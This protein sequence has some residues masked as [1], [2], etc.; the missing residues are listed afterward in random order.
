M[1]DWIPGALPRAAIGRRLLAPDSGLL[2]QGVRFA[3][4][5]SL[6]ALVYLLTTTLLAAVVGLPFQVALPLGLG[7]AIVVHFTLQRM[8]VWTPSG[9]FALPL[10]HQA[11]RYLS[12]V[13]VQYG[14]TAASTALLPHALGIPTEIVFLVTAVLLGATN[15]VVFRH[16]VFHPGAVI[17]GS[18]GRSR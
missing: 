6:T 5:G 13:G 18:E 4:V 15:F 2:G 9:E 17:A 11:G 7:L 10:R 3:L 1:R 14:L 12:V 8:F 16:G